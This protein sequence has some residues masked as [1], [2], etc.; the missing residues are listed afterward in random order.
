MSYTQHEWTTGETITAAK[1]NNIEEGI[2]E[3]AQSGGGDGP[4][5][6]HFDTSTG[7]MDKTV[8][9]IYDAMTSGT[10]AFL[11]YIYGAPGTDYES[12]YSLAP[13]SYIFTYN[14]LSLIRVVVNRP[15]FHGM[16]IGAYDYVFKPATW[17]FSADS[18]NDYPLFYKDVSPASV[19]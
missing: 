10:P 12:N 9:E 17:V 6:V 7:L 8:Q 16:S 3:A 13:I 4:L 1:L 18:M 5:I 11:E 19:E 15:V 2:E 14:N